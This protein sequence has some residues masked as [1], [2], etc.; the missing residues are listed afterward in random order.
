MGVK[1]SPKFKVHG[2]DS[3]LEPPL[4]KKPQFPPSTTRSMGFLFFFKNVS[5]LLF[6]PCWVF[7]AA[8]RL[9]PVAVHGLLILVAS[10]A[11]EHGLQ[12]TQGSIPVTHRL[13]LL[14]GIWNLA[15]LGINVLCIGKWIFNH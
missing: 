12:G 13:S 2:V 5:S 10:L 7:V 11:V 9:S 1:L 15:G 8:C 3:D 4:G 14:S 6:W